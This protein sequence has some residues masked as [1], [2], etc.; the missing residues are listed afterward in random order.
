MTHKCLIFPVPPLHLLLSSPHKTPTTCKAPL[1]SGV[2]ISLIF[3]GVKITICFS[4]SQ[5]QHCCYCFGIPAAQLF[6]SLRVPQILLCPEQP[7]RSLMLRVQYFR[8]L[9][10]PQDTILSTHLS[11][12]DTSSQGEGKNQTKPNQPSCPTHPRLPPSISV[13]RT[14]QTLGLYFPSVL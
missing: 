12:P 9:C 7:F 1:V 5:G 2:S 14:S 11:F 8:R 3:C 4:I 6:I 13:N 10:I